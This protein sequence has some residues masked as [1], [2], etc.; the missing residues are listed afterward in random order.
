MDKEQYA[1]MAAYNELK[2]AIRIKRVDDE[3]TL[4]FMLILF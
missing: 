4:I 2:V 1:M 3:L